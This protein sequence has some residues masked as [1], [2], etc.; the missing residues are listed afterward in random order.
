MGSVQTE[1][2]WFMGF[3]SLSPYGQL[4]TSL[5]PD[6]RASMELASALEPSPMRMAVLPQLHTLAELGVHVEE[7]QREVPC[8]FYVSNFLYTP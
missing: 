3:V 7:H 5:P 8:K 6:L 1:P 4:G 2:L